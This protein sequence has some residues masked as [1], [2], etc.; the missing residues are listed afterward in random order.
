MLTDLELELQ[1]HFDQYTDKTRVCLLVLGE[2]LEG[3]VG[4]QTLEVA[5]QLSQAS[6]QY[7]WGQDDVDQ[8]FR[9]RN[10]EEFQNLARAGMVLGITSRRISCA[11]HRRIEGFLV[12]IRG[13][14]NKS[15]KIISYEV[16]ISDVLLHRLQFHFQSSLLKDRL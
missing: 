6:W 12:A 4:I 15:A 16:D 10:I 9:Q 3:A 7:F 14:A 11:V 13:S 2:I 1:Q 8:S 5:F